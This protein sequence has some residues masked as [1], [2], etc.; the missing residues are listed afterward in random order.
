MLSAI[1]MWI[2]RCFLTDNPEH[3]GKSAQTGDPVIGTSITAVRE[4]QTTCMC[5]VSMKNFEI[6]GSE[7][8]HYVLELKESLFIQK[9]KPVLNTKIR[10]QELA[11][12]T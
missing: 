7:N 11:L 5:E 9:E 4:H 12:F 6:L 2:T 1:L 3:G 8:N 10:S